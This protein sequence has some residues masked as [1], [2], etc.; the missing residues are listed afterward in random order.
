LRSITDTRKV[1]LLLAVVAILIVIYSGICVSRLPEALG[2]QRPGI[3]AIFSPPW[4]NFDVTYDSGS[5]LDF[6]IGM[7]RE[8][9]A[10]VLKARYASDAVLLGTCGEHLKFAVP[11]TAIVRIERADQL[12]KKDVL[13]LWSK[14]THVNLIFYVQNDVLLRVRVT[15]DHW[16]I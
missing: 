12:M 8:A 11:E 13:C 16:G 10:R 2:R 14:S 5:V 3:A 1:F 4:S 15:V 6:K 9:L 7:S